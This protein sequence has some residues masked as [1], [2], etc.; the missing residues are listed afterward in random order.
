M[1]I[2]P[3]SEQFNKLKCLSWFSYSLSPCS[4]Y[5]EL[6][7]MERELIHFE[8]RPENM[9]ILGVPVID[10][11]LFLVSVVL[12]DG[13]SSLRAKENILSNSIRLLVAN[14]SSARSYTETFNPLTILTY[15]PPC[16]HADVVEL[17]KDA[18]CLRKRLLKNMH[19]WLYD[20][21]FHA[22]HD[23]MGFFEELYDWKVD[24]KITLNLID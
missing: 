23:L 20:V 21:V 5:I 17:I 11:F 19:K 12:K 18:H 3:S 1:P 2:E 14:H 22:S 24:S 10:Y 13:H 9:R 15:F 4:L 16:Q 7:V 6:A 8:L